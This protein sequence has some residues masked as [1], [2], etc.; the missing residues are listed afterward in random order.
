MKRSER[1]L[2][3]AATILSL[4]LPAAAQAADAKAAEAIVRKS[5]CLRCHS[6]T[7]KRKEKD[8]PTYGEVAKKNRDK[9][10]I[11][12]KLVARA[13]KGDTVKIDG[14]EEEHGMFKTDDKDQIRNAIQWILSL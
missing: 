12:D 13:I 2:V 4:L 10:G 14:K 8:A 1:C 9:P 11:E 7:D 5:G 6:L 3:L